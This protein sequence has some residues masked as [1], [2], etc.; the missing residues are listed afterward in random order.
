MKAGANM[1]EQQEDQKKKRTQEF[2]LGGIEKP[3]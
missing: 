2:I 1:I 3:Q